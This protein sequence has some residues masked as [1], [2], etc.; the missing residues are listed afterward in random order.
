VLVFR[1][2]KG[3]GGDRKNKNQT[4]GWLKERA[5]EGVRGGRR[6]GRRIRGNEREPVMRFKC[7]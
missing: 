6:S 2:E 7:T 3:E 1:D 5:E 4:K